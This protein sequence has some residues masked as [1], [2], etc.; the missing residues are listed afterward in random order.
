MKLE[1][2][3]RLKLY[4]NMTLS[5]SEQEI[6]TAIRKA[7]E[8]VDRSKTTWD[9]ILDRTIKIEV[10]I[11]S[12]EDANTGPNKVDAATKRREIN[13][14]FDV[15]LSSDPTGDFADFVASL[16]DQW[17]RKGFLSGPQIEALFNAKRR[18]ER[19]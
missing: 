15:V 19:V 3:R 16:K 11:E 9:R 2:F 18:R 8:I 1:D 7:N 13:D 12:F 10:E 17:D 6:L 5:G 14:A 4:M